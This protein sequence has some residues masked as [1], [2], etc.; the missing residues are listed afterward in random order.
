MKLLNILSFALAANAMTLFGVKDCC[1]CKYDANH[2]VIVGRSET[3]MPLPDEP[4]A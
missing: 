3:A 4:V 1:V 2:K